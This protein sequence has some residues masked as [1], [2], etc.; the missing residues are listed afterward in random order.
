[1]G[2][3][4]TM[5]RIPPLLLA[6]PQ[7]SSQSQLI[8]SLQAALESKSKQIIDND[9]QRT[10]LTQALHTANTRIEDLDKK[11]HAAVRDAESDLRD[12][13]DTLLA[14]LEK[15]NKQLIVAQDGEKLWKSRAIT[16][17]NNVERLQRQLAARSA[18]QNESDRDSHPPPTI[19]ILDEGGHAFS[20]STNPTTST[21]NTRRNANTCPECQLTSTE[22][23]EL[24]TETTHLRAKCDVFDDRYRK[25]NEAHVQLSNAHASLERTSTNR[26]ADL[27]QALQDAKDDGLALKE[28][29]D[30][31]ML[32]REVVS[33][34][35][36]QLKY[37]ARLP[38]DASYADPSHVCE[39][40]R[41]RRHA[42]RS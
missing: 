27:Q 24:R 11:R 9:V 15:V 29:R 28:E 8:V 18:A 31:V 38:S 37:C 25:L 19:E 13:L 12:E 1:M 40:R 26:I 4:L 17:E 6:T 33:K 3:G 21:H 41:S 7:L 42:E 10:N 36:G 20:T 39:K 23:A 32:E 30:E 34:E 5:Y 35:V 2:D 22:L 16:A 14:R